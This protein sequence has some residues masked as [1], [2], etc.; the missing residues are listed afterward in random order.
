MKNIVGVGRL[1]LASLPEHSADHGICS[2]KRIHG[3]L[4]RQS[5]FGEASRVRQ[6]SAA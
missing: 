2:R 4:G 1:G 6:R 5:A 3:G